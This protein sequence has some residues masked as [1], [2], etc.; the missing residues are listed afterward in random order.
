MRTERYL[1][2]ACRPPTAVGHPFSIMLFIVVLTGATALGGCASQS[3]TLTSPVNA[4]GTFSQPGS[5]AVPEE[6][7]TAFQDE[8]LNAIVDTALASNFDL[9]TAWERLRAAQAV[10]DREASRLFPAVDGEAR[11]TVA[12]G[13]G[14]AA[15]GTE[16]QLGLS[17]AYEVDLWGGIGAS[18]DAEQYRAQ[19]TRADYQAAALSLSGEVARTVYR[20]V[21]AQGQLELVR[22]QIETNREVLELI[23]NRFGA[24]QVRGVDVLRQQQLVEATAEQ[25][26]R[27]VSRVQLLEQQVAL[28][29]GRPPTRDPGPVA[30]QLPELPP[31][32]E[33]GV[34]VELVRRR[35]DVR[36]AFLQVRAADRSMAAAISNQY[37]R[38]TLNASGTSLSA[39]ADALFQQWAYSFAG[40]L[41]APLFYG[42]ELR[43]EID[44]TE[45]VRQQ[46]LY[47]YA[48]TVLVAF[49]EVEEA[50]TLEKAQ[51][52]QIRRIERQVQM[53]QKAY[54]QL[55][56]QYLNGTGTYLEVL[57]ALDE[58][59]QQRRDLL[60]ARL[61]LVENRIALYRALA[62]PIETIRETN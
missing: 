29:L 61:G 58:L 48:Q 30:D 42:G 15:G 23:E 31:L 21:E 1:Q 19:A 46:R 3:K 22:E 54:E 39:P 35:P 16:L 28:L 9:Q 56:V 34:P 62:G 7:W 40:D 13:Q 44:R 33:T 26:A 12:S 41:L 51:R 14:G 53:G 49:R 50:L 25:R 27:A 32:P 2:L 36:S 20:L 60:S 8:R 10:A 17:A 5:Q 38:L 6:W 4:P 37:P 57:T 55:R 43:A 47:T 45:A 52:R 11:P 59:Q 24:G 18:V